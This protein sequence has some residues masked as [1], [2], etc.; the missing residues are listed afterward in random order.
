MLGLTSQSMRG[1][2]RFIVLVTFVL[3]AMITPPDI[4]SQF[5]LALPTLLFYELAI[6]VVD[7]TEKR[8]AR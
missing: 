7:W 8:R 2:R 1:S 3:A 5:V 6:L 4:T